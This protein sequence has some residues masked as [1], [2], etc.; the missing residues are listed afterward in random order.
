MRR[1]RARKCGERTIKRRE[2][3]KIGEERERM[4]GERTRKSL[5]REEIG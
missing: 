4:R 1:D 2:R 3:Y 5:E